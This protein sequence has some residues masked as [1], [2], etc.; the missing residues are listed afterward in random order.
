MMENHS[1]VR[2]KWH[3]KPSVGFKGKVVILPNGVIDERSHE[4]GQFVIPEHADEYE[5]FDSNSFF[6]SS[7]DDHDRQ[8]EDDSVKEKMHS[9]LGGWY[10]TGG[11][12]EINAKK[13]KAN[14]KKK[15]SEA[16]LADIKE[17]PMLS[18]IN[19]ELNLENDQELEWSS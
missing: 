19:L 4:A 7:L 5:N 3:Q 16:R 10:H 9:S 1:E 6:P 13:H 12:S 14:A 15:E 17:H 2:P 11:E 8:Y 18:K